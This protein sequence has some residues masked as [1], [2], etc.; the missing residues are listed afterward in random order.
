M[1]EKLSKVFWITLS[2]A[3]LAMGL[4]VGNMRPPEANAVPIQGQTPG[5]QYQN[6][7]VST[8]GYLCVV[9]NAGTPVAV[10]IVGPI[11]LQVQL[12]TSVSHFVVVS[13][14]VPVSLVGSSSI[15]AVSPACSTVTTAHKNVTTSQV[16][17]YAADATR[18]QSL[19][20]NGDPVVVMYIGATGVTTGTGV[21]LQ[22]G[23]CFSPD[24][25]ADFQGALFA[26]STGPAQTGALSF[27]ALDP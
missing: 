27:F 5:G 3:V 24:T 2:G 10:T 15:T 14:T 1:K 22:P 21:A 12:S 9:L 11:P 7:C 25:P 13:G 20:C 4:I 16:Q 18:C 23:A 26:I 8:A 17:I 19:I 6:V